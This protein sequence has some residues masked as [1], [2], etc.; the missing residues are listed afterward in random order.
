MNSP[1]EQPDYFSNHHLKL[2]F[3]WRLYH[4]PIIDSLQGAVDEAS[5][6]DLLNLG[7]GPFLE[8]PLIKNRERLNLTACDIDARAMEE[9]R[10][11]FGDELKSCD[12]ITPEAPLPYPDGTFDL[13]TSMDV[14]EHIV[15]PVPWL[16][17]ALR[18]L[19][20]AGR[21]FLTTPNYASTSL[22]IL[23]ATALELVAR[24][25]GFSRRDIHPTKMTPTRLEKLLLDAGGTELEISTVALGWVLTAFA[26]KRRTT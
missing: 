3:P 18:V 16:A 8:L 26:R 4:G 17:E 9:A 19:K 15:D 1:N 2:R 10:R 24:L 14:V 22:N 5:G 6:P 12:V 20:P 21:L 11:L 23:E 25:Q 7:S 13:V